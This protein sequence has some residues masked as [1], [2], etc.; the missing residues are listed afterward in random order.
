[1]AL[2]R[3]CACGW[4]EVTGVTRWRLRD[5]AKNTKEPGPTGGSQ[6]R[7]AKGHADSEDSFKMCSTV[8]KAHRLSLP[9]SVLGVVALFPHYTLSL[10]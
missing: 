1:M 9:L 6:I 10:L 7:C 5:P 8:S 4:E 2:T 3:D